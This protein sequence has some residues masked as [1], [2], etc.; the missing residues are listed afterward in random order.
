MATKDWHF[1]T[2]TIAHSA[3]SWLHAEEAQQVAAFLRTCI[4]PEGLVSSMLIFREQDA[5][6]YLSQV[7]ARTLVMTR[8]D[9]PWLGVDVARGLASRIRGARLV[10]VEGSSIAPVGAE[11]DVLEVVREFLSDESE[12][13]ASRTAVDRQVSLTARE[14]EVLSLLAGGC[15]GKEIA[16]Q[17]TV[18]LS[19]VQ[20]HI[21]NIYAKIGA[22]GRVAAAAYAI[23]HG[24]VQPRDA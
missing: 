3:F 1:F 10:V 4:T 7:A 6:P 14:A 9:V 15:S 12:V 19:T 2:Q 11:G 16:A 24:L 5:T 8:R 21:A 13:P 17:L 18:S 22:H 23:K 20:R